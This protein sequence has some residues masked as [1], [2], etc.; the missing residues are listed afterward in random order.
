MQR[1][2]EVLKLRTKTGKT[3]FMA[4]PLAAQIK[5]QQEKEL[6]NLELEIELDEM[7]TISSTI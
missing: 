7:R 3:I 1:N 6:F 5:E 2:G 4:G